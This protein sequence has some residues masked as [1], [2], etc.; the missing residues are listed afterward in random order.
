MKPNHESEPDR[1]LE[2]VLGEWVV[3]A[4]LPPRFQDQ[5]WQRIGRADVRSA[6][7][8][9]TSLK[10]LMEVV[11]PQPKVAYS[12]LAALMV[13]GVGAGSWA[14][15]RQNERLDAMLGSRYLQSINP[16]QAPSPDR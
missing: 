2:K 3:D 16:Y 4:P 6:P 5:V 12:Y 7:S 11:L 8:L 15:Q 10:R 1:S 9:W 14:A 13:L